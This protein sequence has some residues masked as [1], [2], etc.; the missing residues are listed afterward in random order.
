[1]R[2]LQFLSSLLLIGVGT[3]L[4][5]LFLYM[6]AVGSVAVIEEN[7]WIWGTEVALWVICIIIGTISAVNTACGNK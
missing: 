7:V 5:F 4:L 6:R 1:M 2:F 3:A